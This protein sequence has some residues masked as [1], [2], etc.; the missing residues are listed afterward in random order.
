MTVQRIDLG[1]EDIVREAPRLTTE[2]FDRLPFGTIHLDPEGTI[3]IYNKAEEALSGRHRDDVIGL[4][5][6][7]QVAPCTRVREFYGVFRDGV[8]RGQLNEVFDFT[9]RFATGAKH[10]RIRMI[11]ADVPS[12]GVWLFVTPIDAS[13]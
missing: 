13:L 6:F 11:F 1:P 10:V 7:T 8:A 4:N 9:F 2:D 12:R 5:F 3:R